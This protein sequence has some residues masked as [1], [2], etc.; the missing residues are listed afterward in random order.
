[1]HTLR[2]IAIKEAI[3]KFKGKPEMVSFFRDTVDAIVTFAQ[4][5]LDRRADI[6]RQYKKLVEDMKEEHRKQMAALNDKLL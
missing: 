1:M 4:E 3:E 5:E 6:I 2:N